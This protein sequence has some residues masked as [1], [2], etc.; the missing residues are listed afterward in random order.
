MAIMGLALHFYSQ[1]KVMGLTSTQIHN[2]WSA[3]LVE[4]ADRV[5]LAAVSQYYGYKV[6]KDKEYRPHEKKSYEAG[7]VQPVLCNLLHLD[8]FQRGL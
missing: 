3:A 2:Y 6:S 1:K 8:P 5:D 7:K 4:E